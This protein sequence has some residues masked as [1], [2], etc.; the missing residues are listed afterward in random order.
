MHRL[1]L[2]A[3]LLSGPALA[4]PP[5]LTWS[6]FP[7]TVKACELLEVNC[8]GIKNPMLIVAE[9]QRDLLGMYP[10]GTNVVLLS[11]QCMSRLADEDFCRAILIHEIAHYVLYQLNPNISACDSEAAAWDVFNAY[12]M[13][14]GRGRLVRTDW[15]E[16]YPQCAKS[17][18]SST[19]SDTQ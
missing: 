10:H 7:E 16:S 4:G 12:V 5:L 17:P 15:K 11:R 18:N 9:L 13:S 14:I 1:L 19:S 6:T 8:K 3:L 2:A